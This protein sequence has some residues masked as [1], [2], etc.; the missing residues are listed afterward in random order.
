MKTGKLF[1]AGVLAMFLS[2]GL[3]QAKIPVV[4]MDDAAKAQAEAKK[5][6]AAEASKKAAEALA[7]A[8]DRVVE[9]YK[10]GPGKSESKSSKPM[11]A[12]KK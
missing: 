3:A 8:Q 6:S 9:R 10:K 4:P 2:A 5:A 12:A 7:K 1:A 11:A